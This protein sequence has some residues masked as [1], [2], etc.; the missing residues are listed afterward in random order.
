[1]SAEE[2][3]VQK[4]PHIQEVVDVDFG[5]TGSLQVIKED[6]VYHVIVD[7]V[8]RHPDCS[9]EDVMRAL[10]HYVNSLSYQLSKK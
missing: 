7:G 5:A 8:T 10:G 6:D 3:S 2:M 4:K 9:A 1:M